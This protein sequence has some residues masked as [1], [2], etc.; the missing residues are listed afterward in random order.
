MTPGARSVRSRGRA[1]VETNVKVSQRLSGRAP[2]LV[3]LLL[4]TAAPA[5]CGSHGAAVTQ[6][7]SEAPQQ[8]SDLTSS[9]SS[10]YA[11]ARLPA[12][13]KQSVNF[14]P[15]PPRPDDWFEDVTERTGIHFEY[16][17]GGTAGFYTL[18]ETVGGG[19]AMLD[20]DRDGRMDLFLTGGGE[21]T[22]PP[23][24]VHGRS[25][26]LY[27]NDGSW[28]FTDVTHEA[29]L[30]DAGL[31]THG[32]AVGDFDRDGYPDLFVGGYHGCRLYRND[33]HGHFIDVTA[34]CGI[35]C[36]DWNVVGCWA[37]IDNDGWLDLY[38][39][40]YADCEPD[41]KKRCL[42]DNDV[43]DVC[44]PSSHLGSQNRIF[45]NRGDGTFEDVT[46]R[47]GLVPRNKGLG[48]V[49][50]DFNDDGWVDFFVANDA[51]A[52]QL[53]FGG[54]GCRFR[55]E[56]LMSGVAFSADGAVEGSMGCDVGDFDG[57]GLP[58]IFYC[59]F[60]GQDNS[61]CRR[62][63]GGSGFLNIG[64]MTGMVGV[65]RPWVG[66]GT[67]FADFDNDGWLDIVV[68]NGHVW[69]E[70]RKSPYFQPAQLF[71]NDS[72]KRFVEV[73]DK[74]GPYFSIPHAGRGVAIG[75]LDNDGALDLVISRQNDPVVVLRGRAPV[76]KNWFR[77]ELRGA[78]SNPDA[79]GAKISTTYRGRTL[80]RWVR[81]GGGFCSHFDPRVVFPAADGQPRGVSVKW[82]SGKTEVFA[83]LAPGETHVLREGTGRKP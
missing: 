42:N 79:V 17:D 51:E 43:Q 76:G 7:E 66:F 62:N 32:G 74:G 75:D 12:E 73:S 4:V 3:I 46:A 33:R 41:H 18:L 2:V 59:N 27:H 57:D 23:I 77:V 71:R 82:P 55:E 30:D 25:C 14:I 78:E 6:P 63:P 80:V 9:R 11:K 64:E 10:K 52:N 5:G 19:A 39:L 20:F 47:A 65:S 13:L 70:S 29:G 54:P 40:T 38:V 53:Y 26:K 37:D 15:R 44:A 31:Y 35:R 60:D 45:R 81:G 21:M 56:G 28:H 69:Y 1:P 68:S 8:S 50:A 16:H 61:L 36:P 22:G 67:G 48:V 58:D 24:V 83:G 72:G 49:A 34:S